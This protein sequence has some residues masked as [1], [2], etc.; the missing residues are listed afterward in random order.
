VDISTAS[1]LWL[2]SAGEV[3][4]V[5]PQL[6]ESVVA[7]VFTGPATVEGSTPRKLVGAEGFMEIRL[8]VDG[9]AHAFATAG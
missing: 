5:D 7:H 9:S 1:E 4:G 3:C 2:S 8:G 6:P